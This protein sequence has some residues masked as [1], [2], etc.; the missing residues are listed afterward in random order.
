MRVWI[1]SILVV[2]SVLGIGGDVRAQT[3]AAVDDR[4]RTVIMGI[5]P[6]RGVKDPE[7]AHM[8]SDVVLGSYS[9][10]T[11]RMVIGPDDIRRALEWEASRQQAGCDDSKCLAEVGSA[12]N[13]HRIVSGTLDQIGEGYLLSLSE[14]DAQTLE[15]IARV[16]EEVKK[17]ESELVKTTRR[18]A[19]ELVAKA[20]QSKATVAAAIFS[21]TAGSIEFTTDPRGAVVLV[22]GQPIGTTPTRIENVNAG[23]HSVRIT[24]DDYETVDVEVPV[25]SGGTTK[26]MVEMRILRALAQQNLEIRQA[27]WR[28]TDE[29]VRIAGWSKGVGGVVLGSAGAL[30]T[31]GSLTNGGK[32]FDGQTLIGLSGLGLGAG[33]IGWGAVD[34]LNPPKPPVAEWEMERKVTVTPPKG[35][36]DAEVKLIQEAAK[37]AA[38]R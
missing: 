10:D 37:P 18:M 3:A 12:L 5:A 35:S 34:L 2:G 26:V 31:V 7:L 25:H 11:H 29:F 33:L 6:R 24:R 38:I 32:V 8:L 19:D 22:G 17:D 28:E 1:A 21:G 9:N 27:K 36:G 13:A 14:I 23:R 4:L 15:P 30:I 20:L 16:Q